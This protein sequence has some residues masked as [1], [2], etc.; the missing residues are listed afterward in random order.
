MVSSGAWRAKE[1]IGYEKE[2]VIIGSLL[3][4]LTKQEDSGL[5]HSQKG[6]LL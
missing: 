3:F 2:W 6:E 5:R 4:D 1:W